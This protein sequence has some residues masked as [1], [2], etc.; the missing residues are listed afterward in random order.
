[1]S[2]TNFE[3]TYCFNL[4]LIRNAIYILLWLIFMKYMFLRTL[5]SFL[6][7]FLTY[8]CIFYSLS[9]VLVKSFQ[10]IYY[11]LMC[12]EFWEG[13]RYFGLITCFSMLSCSY[14]IFLGFSERLRCF[15]LRTYFIFLLYSMGYYYIF[16]IH[17]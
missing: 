10:K 13:L 16:V 9:C 6:S 4:I 2:Q 8:F 5:A 12:L 14:I 1:M 11:I 17:S 3:W 7:L 15:A